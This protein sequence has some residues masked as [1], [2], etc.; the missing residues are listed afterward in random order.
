RSIATEATSSPHFHWRSVLATK[1]LA[2]GTLA[3]VGLS[4]QA[5]S[6]RI[7]SSVVR[8]EWVSP[9]HWQWFRRLPPD[10][11]AV[12]RSRSAIPPL[13]QRSVDGWLASAVRRAPRSGAPNP[14]PDL[15]VVGST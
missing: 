3:V 8:A 9:P 4:V 14:S 15:R 10:R 11:P 1:C 7:S 13:R 5:A 12:Q 6:R 2:A